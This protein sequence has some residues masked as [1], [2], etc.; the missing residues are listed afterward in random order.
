M[1]RFVPINSAADFCKTFFPLVRTLFPESRRCV[2]KCVLVCLHVFPGGTSSHAARQQHVS[3]A[4]TTALPTIEK[5]IRQC[6]VGARFLRRDLTLARILS[7][8]LI[9]K[10]WLWNRERRER[11]IKSYNRWQKSTPYN[12]WMVGEEVCPMGRQIRPMLEFS[13]SSLSLLSN[14]EYNSLVVD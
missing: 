6:L 2:S 10:L 8:G 3:I 1:K 13:D 5:D 14:S 4:T 12:K 7:T 11:E 9:K